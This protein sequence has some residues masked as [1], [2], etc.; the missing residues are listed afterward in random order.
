MLET[1]YLNSATATRGSKTASLFVDAPFQGNETLWI[2][3]AIRMPNDNGFVYK[4]FLNSFVNPKEAQAK[5]LIVDNIGIKIDYQINSLARTNIIEFSSENELDSIVAKI[6]DE[7]HIINFSDIYLGP[8]SE[9]NSAILVVNQE[10]PQQIYEWTEFYAKNHGLEALVILTRNDLDQNVSAWNGKFSDLLSKFKIDINIVICSNHA[11]LGKNEPSA[12]EIYMSPDA[13][14]K[15]RMEV[16]ANDPWHSEL[17]GP[18]ILELMKLRFLSEA[19]AVL[20][21]QP[22]DILPKITN[23]I[24]DM[25]I[26]N[27]D[28]YIQLFGHK[29]F[30]WR[31]RKNDKVSFGDHCC[32]PFTDTG[33]NKG[34]CVAPKG[35]R[36][37]DIWNLFRVG[38]IGEQASD[39]QIFWRMVGTRHFDKKD[40]NPTLI[41]KT[42]LVLDK[43]LLKLVKKQFGGNPVLPPEKTQIEH[44]KA[45]DCG[46]SLIVTTMKN[47]G[48][49]LLE[50]IAYHKAIGFDDFIVFTNDCTD[51]TDEFFDLLHK[52]GIVEHR[53]NP[54][55]EVDMKPQHAALADVKNSKIFKKADWVVCMDVDEYVNIHV[56]DGTLKALF[57]AV[58]DANM[59]SMTWRLIGNSNVVDFVDKPIIEQFNKA[60]HE[61]T[62]FPHQAWGVKTLYRQL[63]LFKKMGVHRPKGLKPEQKDHIKWVN[64]SGKTLPETFYR[65]AWRT[66]TATVG[67]DLVSL[68]HYAVRSMES[69]LVKRDRGRVNHVDRDQGLHYWFRMNHNVVEDNSIKRMIPK[70][71]IELDKLMADPEIAAFHHSCVK[72]HRDKIAELLTT[73][74]YKEFFALINSE[75]LREL[76]QYTN[77]FGM[78]VYEIGEHVIDDNVI[79]QLK[80]GSIEYFNVKNDGTPYT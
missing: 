41:A 32:V 61:M 24:F 63:G 15:E 71:Q 78:N 5:L 69:F 60:A 72:A 70:M 35:Q 29:C 73:D 13:P 45:V 53:F 23:N 8:F 2:I 20:H 39:A 6:E 54:Y 67:Y 14:G 19:R 79:K 28:G 44:K 46:R 48:P 59:I 74:A 3:D 22:S 52:K 36:Q 57:E 75:R 9:K 47:E 10:T 43:D 30:P 31:V 18:I 42:A 11:P 38:A 26:A 66:G 49:F 50:W 55:R 33:S 65:T 64:G 62:R 40:H 21:L 16:P 34:W 17:S 80:S 7:Q 27:E 51:G 12:R 58:G 37:K 4:I 56:G 77:K 1:K 25:T 76:S 68:N